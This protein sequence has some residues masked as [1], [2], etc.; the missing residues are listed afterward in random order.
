LQCLEITKAWL[1]GDGRGKQRTDCAQH[2]V[3]LI[4]G[5]PALGRIIA[6]P[7]KNEKEKLD[8]IAGGNRA[9]EKCQT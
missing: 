1:K 4:E 6:I 9:H 5:K 7:I 8:C 3:L 2:E